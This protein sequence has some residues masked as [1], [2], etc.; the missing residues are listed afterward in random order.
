MP[1][2]RSPMTAKSAFRHC[3]LQKWSNEQAGEP[4]VEL[5]RDGPDLMESDSLEDAL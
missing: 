2:L 4:A 1:P 5:P 3:N